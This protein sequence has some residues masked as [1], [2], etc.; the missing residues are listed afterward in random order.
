MKKQTIETVAKILLSKKVSFN[1]EN[2][3]LKVTDQNVRYELFEIA[4][5]HS[6]TK[7]LILQCIDYTKAISFDEFLKYFAK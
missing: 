4:C 7:K 2:D 3:Y 1:Y 5:Y 6:E